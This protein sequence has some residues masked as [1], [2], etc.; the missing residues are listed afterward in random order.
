MPKIGASIPLRLR[1]L[2]IPVLGMVLLVVVWDLAVRIFDIA[3]YVLPSPARTFEA[4]RDDWSS[5]GPGA[6]ITSQEFILGFLIGA[7]AGFFFALVMS[8]SPLVQRGLYPILITSQAVPIIAVAP[9]L[10]IW[11]GFGLAPKLTIVALIVFFP[12][13]VNVLDGLASVD[14]DLIALVKAM[15][16][17]R[18]RIFRSVTLPATLTPLFSAL[19][20]TAT[21][22]VTGA[23]LG[24]WTASTTGGLGVSLLEAQSRLDVASVFAAIILLV[25]LG[26]LAF[27]TVAVAEVL[28]TPWRRSSVK[29]AWRRTLS[30][31]VEPEP[32]KVNQP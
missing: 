17:T 21:F 9:A 4:L 23:V 14:K 2:G 31:D 1:A 15:G 19:K 18:W 28:L 20:M 7:T 11:M 10:V 5:L 22:A 8:W 27:G 3:P 30:R 24:E 26:L 32:E 25:I 29:P 6:V 13:V 12:V 16:G